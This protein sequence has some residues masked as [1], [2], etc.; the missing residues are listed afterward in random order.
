MPVWQKSL[1]SCCRLLPCLWLLVGPAI[2]AE[3]STAAGDDQPIETSCDRIGALAKK[4]EKQSELW[5]EIFLVTTVKAV[6]PA[7]P[8]A[9]TELCPGKRLQVICLE[10]DNSELKPGDRVE[11]SGLMTKSFDGGVVIDPCSAV[12]PQQN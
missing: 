1:A 6:H 8:I 11:V 10:Y 2:A 7:D 4:W 3:T 5:P 9:V 12:A